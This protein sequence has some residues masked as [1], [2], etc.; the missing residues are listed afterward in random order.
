MAVDWIE[1]RA[2]LPAV[3]EDW[4]YLASLFQDAGCP[5]TLQTD[6][7]PTITAYLEDVS[8]ASE[9]AAE[10]RERLLA[11]GAAEVEFRTVP[12]SDW[13]ES[14]KQHF[15]PRRVGKR[16]VIKPTWETCESSANDLVI[17]LDPGQAFGTGDHPTTRLC[18][19][20]LESA[21]VAGKRVADIGCGS[22]ILSIGAV[23][24]GASEVYASD[25]EA[26]SVEI[27]KENASRNS[28]SFQCETAEGFAGARG[29]WDV[30]VSNI[31]SATLMRLA[32]EAA[33]HVQPGGF[34][35]VSGIYRSNWEDVR[36]AAERSGFTL[37]QTAEED[38]WVG[39]TFRR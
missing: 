30:L 34:W 17:V 37:V 22:G 38:D 7:P 20:L 3:P 1:I 12:D 13:A 35:I 31:I 29:K 8:G 39:A 24:L 36:S 16:F 28:V 21:D 25:I 9:A 6:R 26:S 4:S 2:T 5:S 27:S 14:W 32:P 19:E 33:E 23:L 18:L 10:L 15:K 11:S